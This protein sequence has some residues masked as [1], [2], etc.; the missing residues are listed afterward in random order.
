MNPFPEEDWKL[1]RSKISDWQEAYMKKLN[2]EY[3][4]ILSG[5]GYESDKFWALEKRIRED[6]NDCGVHCRMSR[7][8][9]LSVMVSLLNEG[10]I[11]FDDLEGFS[12]DLKNTLRHFVK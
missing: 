12:D 5:D 9:L 1:F 6:K 8:N 10:A 4:E 11:T 7:S 2:Q 3:I